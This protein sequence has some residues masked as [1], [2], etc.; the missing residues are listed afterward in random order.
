MHNRRR[1]EVSTTQ[2]TVVDE[3]QVGTMEAFQECLHDKDSS[4]CPL[5][6]FYDV[7]CESEKS[8]IQNIQKGDHVFVHETLKW[9]VLVYPE[10]LPDESAFLIWRA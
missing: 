8:F 2:D 9:Y 4:T 5:T 7:Q 10:N 1:I 3:Q 6:V